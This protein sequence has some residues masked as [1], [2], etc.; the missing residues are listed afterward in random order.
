MHTLEVLSQKRK[1]TADCEKT[2]VLCPWVCDQL[3][4][5]DGT[6]EVIW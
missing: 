2:N 6:D 4:I 3:S 5:A 1:Q